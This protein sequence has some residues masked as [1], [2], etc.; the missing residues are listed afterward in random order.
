M[1]FSARFATTTSSQIAKSLNIAQ[2]LVGTITTSPLGAGDRL[3]AKPELPTVT[4]VIELA[5]IDLSKACTAIQGVDNR[6]IREII[7]HRAKNPSRK[8]S[9]QHFP[10]L[11]EA[12]EVIDGRQLGPAAVF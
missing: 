7:S 2:P 3:A 6:E 10:S 9:S 1:A 5:D 12:F 8:H 4:R 11:E